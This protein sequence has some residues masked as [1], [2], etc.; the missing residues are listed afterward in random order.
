MN[1][2]KEKQNRPVFH[3]F[4]QSSELREMIT[5]IQPGML[6][7]QCLSCHNRD[8]LQVW[9][10]FCWVSSTVFEELVE[11]EMNWIASS[12]QILSTLNYNCR[13]RLMAWDGKQ[14]NKR[15]QQIWKTANQAANP[16]Q[17][18]RCVFSWGLADYLRQ[19]HW[20]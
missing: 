18:Q 10:S 7:Y 9:S 12:T 5:D 2:F 1:V 17:S 19:V 14:R 13:H 15:Y 8:S 6:Y 4:T 11:T 16:V 20:N 3:L